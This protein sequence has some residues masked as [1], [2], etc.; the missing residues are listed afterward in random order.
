MQNPDP[1][2]HPNG[3][4]FTLDNRFRG[5]DLVT[6]ATGV[7]DYRFDLWRVQPTEGADYEAVNLRPD[8]PDVS[9]DLNVASFNVLNYFTT[10]G[11]R[12]ATDAGGVRP[13]GG[14]DRRG[15][16]GDGR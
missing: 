2:I 8:A 4:E 12:G 13:A 11:S 1:A 9:S 10:L 6:N 14:E 5:G 15:P 3:D 7:L 16:E